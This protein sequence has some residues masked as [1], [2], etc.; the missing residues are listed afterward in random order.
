MSESKR[1]FAIDEKHKTY[2]IVQ[3]VFFFTGTPLKS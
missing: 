1:F 2:L 3:G